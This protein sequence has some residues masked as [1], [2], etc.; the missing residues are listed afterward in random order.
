MTRLSQEYG[1]NLYLKRDDQTG[2]LTS[3]NK[4]RKLEFLVREAQ[5]QRCD[6]LVTCGALQ[7]NHARATAAVAAKM[8]LKCLLVLRGNPQEVFEGNILLDRF[9]G[10]DIFYVTPEEYQKIDEVFTSIDQRLRKSGR[11]PYLIPEGGSNA[12]GAFGYVAALEEIY[13]QLKAQ[14]LRVNSVVCAVGSGG[15]YAGLLLG[16]KLLD[17][18]AEIY[19]INVGDTAEYF[20]DRILGI[21]GKAIQRYHL[22]VQIKKEEIQIIDGYVGLG[23][24]Q[25]QT[26]ELELIRDIA[27]KEGIVLDPVYTG[28]A[29]HGLLDLLRKQPKRFGENV[30]FLHTGGIFGLFGISKELSR[31]L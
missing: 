9:L 5:D 21:V 28:K 25:S 12:L 19:G 15:T 1:I 4:I 24:G 7:S 23:Y 17:L 30:L 31:L 14:D 2:M 27:R 8:G 3:G 13:H 20:Q 16:K 29:M 22:P 10:A 18:S 11:K 26:Q 6:T